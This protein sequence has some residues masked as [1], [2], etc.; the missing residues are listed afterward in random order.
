MITINIDFHCKLCNNN[1]EFYAMPLDEKVG[2]NESVPSINVYK[3]MCKKCKKS[4]IL[5]Y[6]IKMI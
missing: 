3:L 2:E 6:D 1:T 4:Y 5:H